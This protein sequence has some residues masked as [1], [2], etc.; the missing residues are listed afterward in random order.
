MKTKINPQESQD[1]HY[2]ATETGLNLVRRGG[3]AFMSD[4]AP[5]YMYIHRKFAPNELCDINEINMRSKLLLAFVA[6][7]QS[8][9]KELLKAKYCV[10]MYIIFKMLSFIFRYRKFR[11]YGILSKYQ[12]VWSPS[13]PP[14]MADSIV[15]AVG[16]EYA[17]PLLVFLA[18][19][20]LISFFILMVEIIDYRLFAAHRTGATN[21]ERLFD[22]Q[23]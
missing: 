16:L 4:V 14:C 10:F 8:P 19:S 17:G 9:Y 22:Y 5:A 20:M 12:R 21:V 1:T 13:K 6:H 15:F 3:Y 23:P 7:K 18:V 11:D 2:V